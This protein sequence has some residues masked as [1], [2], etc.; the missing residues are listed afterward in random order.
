MSIAIESASSLSGLVTIS[1]VTAWSPHVI[2]EMYRLYRPSKR[3]R[4]NTSQKMHCRECKCVIS[5]SSAVVVDDNAIEMLPEHCHEYRHQ[6]GAVVVSYS[7]AGIRLIGYTEGLH[8]N[9]VTI[10]IIGISNTSHQASDRVN[11]SS[12]P[13]TTTPSGRR[14]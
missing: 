14:K 4:V 3:N 8:S 12:L 11:I 10:I 2:T 5:A 7:F 6:R 9:T 13:S 1:A